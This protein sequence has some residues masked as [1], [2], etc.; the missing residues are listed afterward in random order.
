MSDPRS[1]LNR[2]TDLMRQTCYPAQGARLCHGYGVAVPTPTPPPAGR[3]H[4]Y[5]DGATLDV[6]AGREG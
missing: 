6:A 2:H 4:D 3:S 1:H 5:N